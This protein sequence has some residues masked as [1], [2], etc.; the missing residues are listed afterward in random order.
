[1]ES[2]SGIPA[3]SHRCY[4]PDPITSTAEAG[5]ARMGLGLAHAGAG[6]VFSREG[7]PAQAGS[8]PATPQQ[9]PA[10]RALPALHHQPRCSPGI[11]AGVEEAPGHLAEGDPGWPGLYSPCRAN[12]GALWELL[13]F[14]SR[15]TKNTDVNLSNDVHWNRDVHLK[16]VVHWNHD[17][18]WNHETGSFLI[19]R[20]TAVACSSH[21]LVGLPNPFLL[22]FQNE[23]LSSLRKSRLQYLQRCEELEK[24]KHLSAKAEDEYQSVAATNPGSA[25]KQLEK[26]RRSCEEA[27]AKVMSSVQ[28]GIYSQPS[29]MHLP[30]H[31]G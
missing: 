10:A 19:S 3:P 29:H 16:D 12:P 5:R 6:L 20:V 28:A 23:S 7:S 4:L 21:R 15:G 31:P 27:Q 8:G 14:G 26:R 1:M 25:N 13:N 2:A 17:V 11:P 30:T 9:S 18:H 24:A 22:L